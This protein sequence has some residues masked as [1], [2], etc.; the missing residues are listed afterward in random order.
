MYK[1]VVEVYA[2]V[3]ID[4]QTQASVLQTSLGILLIL[5]KMQRRCPFTSHLAA[6]HT[7]LLPSPFSSFP[8]PYLGGS[9]HTAQTCVPVRFDIVA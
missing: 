4:K 1:T 6:L 7:F 2:N 3:N 9:R 8:T 5:C